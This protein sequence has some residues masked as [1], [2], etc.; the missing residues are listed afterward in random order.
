VVHLKADDP[1]PALL[2]FA[3]SHGVGQII[4]GRSRAA[5]WRQLLGRTIAMRL[6]KEA[7]GLD[8]LIASIE[9][10]T[11]RP[12]PGPLREPSPAGATDVAERSRAR[13]PRP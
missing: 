1:V 10:E 11:P 3:R 2:D 6:V 4:V 12:T 8:I 7:D 9:E 13:E 5:W